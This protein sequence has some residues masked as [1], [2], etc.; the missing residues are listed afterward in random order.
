MSIKATWQRKNNKNIWKNAQ[1]PG[2]NL[3]YDVIISRFLTTMFRLKITFYITLTHFPLISRAFQKIKVIQLKSW[4]IFLRN[5]VSYI[6]S[7]AGSVLPIEII[8][9]W[10]HLTLNVT[11]RHRNEPRRGSPPFSVPHLRITPYNSHKPYRPHPSI[12]S[13]GYLRAI[14]VQLCSKS[15]SSPT[16]L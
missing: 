14:S 10:F 5:K 15:P 7:C 2:T 12:S 3:N 1:L 8:S 9:V 16:I 11:N 4:Y 6:N 13:P